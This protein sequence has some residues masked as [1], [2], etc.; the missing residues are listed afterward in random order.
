MST[1]SGQLLQQ[2]PL[3]SSVTQI[4]LQ[5]DL[6]LMY[7]AGQYIQVEPKQLDSAFFTVANA[8]AVA[9]YA[10][11]GHLS[12]APNLIELHI[13]QDTANKIIDL[14]QRQAQR[15]NLCG[16]YGSCHVGQLQFDCSALVLIGSGTGY[17]Q[18]KA[19]TEWLIQQGSQRPTYLY[20]GA[21]QRRAVFA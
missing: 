15:L 17:A 1:V 5:L 21:H 16:P 8:P 19:F 7:Q 4:I 12:T 3:S 9:P 10:L 18:L 6:P 11:P 14:A 2:R 20:W 13:Q